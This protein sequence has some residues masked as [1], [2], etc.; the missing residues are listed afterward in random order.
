MVKI[1]E[2]INNG[3]YVRI[4]EV[5]DKFI[6]DTLDKIVEVAKEAANRC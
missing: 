5:V 2:V 4:K 3:N 6:T 1:T